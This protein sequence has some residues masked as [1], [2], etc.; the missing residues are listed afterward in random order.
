LRIYIKL[1]YVDYPELQVV[2]ISSSILEIYRGDSD[3]S[4]RAVSYLL[5][6]LSLREFTELELGTVLPAVSL[7]QVLKDHL[8][9]SYQILEQIKPI[10]IF[11]NYRK[12]RAYPFSKEG[13]VIT[14]KSCEKPFC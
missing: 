14:L 8:S 7:D 2:F 13:K 10:P 12:W 4:R 9:I 3:L 1:I 6:E 11:Q 5:P